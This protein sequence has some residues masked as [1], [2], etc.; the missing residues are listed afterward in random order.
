MKSWGGLPEAEHWVFNERGQAEG[1][2]TEDHYMRVYELAKQL[3]VSNKE[4]LD[5]LHNLGVE[6]KS[7]SS[8]I[9]DKAVRLVF[10]QEEKKKAPAAP[11]KEEADKKIQKVA[12]PRKPP[13]A[14]MAPEPPKEAPPRIDARAIAL[15]A[16]A[17]AK[18]RKRD[19]VQQQQLAEVEEK[20][21][22]PDK[23][24]LAPPKPQRVDL[25]AEKPHVQPPP[26]PP[27][28]GV[29]VGTATPVPAERKPEVREK[30]VAP[31][32]AEQ[33]P[34][35]SRP[36]MRRRTVELEQLPSLPKRTPAPSHGPRKKIPDLTIPPSIEVMKLRPTRRPGGGKRTETEEE[37]AARKKGLRTKGTSG[38]EKRI[39]PGRFINLENLEET[40]ID[41]GTGKRVIRPRATVL[42]GR[43]KIPAFKRSL[44][45]ALAPIPKVVKIYGDLTVGEF[46]EKM[47]VTPAEIISKAFEMGEMLTVNKLISSEMCELLAAAFEVTVEVI[48]EGDEYDIKALLPADVD[49]AHLKSRPPVVTIM[50]HVD[51]GKTTLLDAI[52]KTNVAEGEFGGITQHIGAYHVETER[53][54]IVFLDTPGHEA[55][56]AMRA[57]GAGVTD[58]VVLT[59]AA[60]DGLMPQTVEAINH[61]R[62]AKVP[63][64]VAINKIDLPGA[65]IHKVRTELMQ[66]SL[67]GEE[68]GGDTIICEISAKKAI[69]IDNLLEMILLQAEIME[70]K[71]NPGIPAQGVV[72]ESKIDPQR[73]INATVLIRQGT[74]KAGDPFVCGDV[75]GR[76][77][78]MRNDRGNLVQ[79]AP[80]AHPVEILGLDGCPQVGEK[81]LVVESERQARQIAQVREV[82]RRRQVQNAALRP[83]VTLEGLAD[84]L[85]QDDKPKI[86]N[87]I[88]KA[89]VQGSV[90]A[91]SQSMNRLSTGKVTINILHGGVGAVTESD[92]QLAMASDAIIIGF[93]VRPDAGAADLARTEGIEVKTYRIIYNL[94]EEL[95]A[96]MLGMLDKKFREVARGSAEIRQVFRV[97][98]MGNIAGCYVTHGAVSRGDKMRLVRDGA[99]VHEGELSSLRRIKDDVS[100]VQ[101]GYECGI[102][103]R[104]YQDIKEGDV[105]ETYGFEEVDQTL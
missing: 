15:E 71:A 82:R 56:T 32:P 91:V 83:H 66:Y 98:R 103:I 84:Y 37:K 94:L 4:L 70:L 7:H 48:P 46:A 49:P 20:P 93:N 102:T 38:G 86:L 52:R 34:R 62:A 36:D 65:N 75:S 30:A 60:D 41:V 35:P 68:L 78:Q 2:G 27:A 42:T 99:V 88:L 51:H 69:G 67:L 57:R 45:P 3:G 23:T 24:A 64:L 96:A 97:S 85:N 79:D 22:A 13:K 21:A 72:I 14:K 6:V 29:P 59:V 9:D 39:R 17:R 16:I 80:P 58:I 73:G 87:L 19:Q 54:E 25:G 1:E 89:D 95:H 40:V 81:F 101:S 26:V 63:I 11:S 18:A 55:F 43:E 105:I 104:D 28:M 47:N 61:A 50:G 76:V 10:E 44:R 100:S 90:E 53:G 8:S 33:R 74:L 5:R 92:V 77:R 31:A 12:A